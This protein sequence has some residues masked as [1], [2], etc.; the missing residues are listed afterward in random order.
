[1][2]IIPDILT[3]NQVCAIIEKV[4]YSKSEAVYYEQKNRF[5]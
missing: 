4:D 1:M 3:L 5:R 2:Q